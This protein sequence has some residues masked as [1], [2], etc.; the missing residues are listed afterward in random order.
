MT[1]RPAPADNLMTTDDLA[2]YLAISRHSV[3]R[4][5]KSG[6]IPTVRVGH[7]IRFRPVDV[8]EFLNRVRQ[9]STR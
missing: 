8:E 6:V 7:R 2:E 3:Y 9:A 1:G 5:I 4:L